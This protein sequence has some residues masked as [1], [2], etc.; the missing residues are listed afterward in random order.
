MNLREL[1]NEGSKIVRN[2]PNL[3]TEINDLYC[4]AKDEI[5]EGGSEDHECEL[6]YS[7]MVTLSEGGSLCIIQ[8]ADCKRLV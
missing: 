7:D 5:E 8:T 4:L 3:R 2:N 6:A 1:A